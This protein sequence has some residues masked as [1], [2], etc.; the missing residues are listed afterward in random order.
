MGAKHKL[1]AAHFQG[2]LLVSGLVG[3]LAESWGVFLLAL[4]ALLL[5]ACHTGDIRR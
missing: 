3:W 1:N 4:A 5:G 2:A